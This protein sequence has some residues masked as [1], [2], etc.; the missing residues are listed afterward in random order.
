MKQK[1]YDHLVNFHAGATKRVNEESSVV[2]CC[3]LEDDSE[4]G[5]GA[6]SMAY[7]CANLNASSAP[8]EIM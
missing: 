8:S 2:H 5:K 1:I 6:E 7:E 3:N 4:K